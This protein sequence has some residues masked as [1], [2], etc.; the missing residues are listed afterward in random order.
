[1]V[2]RVYP[3]PMP[4]PIE[5]IKGKMQDAGLRNKDLVGKMGSKIYEVRYILLP[6]S[7]IS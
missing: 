7:A 5:T 4:D 3:V 1:M 6:T 2:M